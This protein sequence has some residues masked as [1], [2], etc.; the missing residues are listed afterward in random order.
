MHGPTNPK[1]IIVND[2]IYTEYRM[3]TKEICI[4]KMMQKTN[5]AYS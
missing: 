5:A 2:S 4:F 1:F 3:S